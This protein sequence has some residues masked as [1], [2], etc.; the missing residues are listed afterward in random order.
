M[1]NF[2]INFANPWLLLLLIPA[3]LLTF[4]PYFR[5]NKRYRGTRNRIVSIVLHSIVM[6]LAISVLAGI[7]FEYDEPND[8][9]EV[10]LLVDASFSGSDVEDEKDEFIESVIKTNNGMFRLGIVSFGFDQVY[11][12]ELTDNMNNAYSQ[13]ISSALPD[14]TATDIEGALKYAASLFT[15]PE[16]GRIVLLTDGIETDGAAL[17]IIKNI[18]ADGIKVDTVDF[19]DDR[20]GDEVQ[21]IAMQG[22]DTKIKFTEEFTV[23]L[24]IQSSF[25]GDATITSYNDDE[26][27]GAVEVELIRGIQTVKIPFTFE[28]PNPNNLHK[29]SFEI[30]SRND[31]LTQNNTFNSYL[32]VESFNKVL[33]LEGIYGESD[34]VVRMLG[35]DFDITTVHIADTENVP[36]SLDNIRLYDQVILCNVSYSDMPVGFDKILYDYVYEIGGGLFTVCGNE[37]DSDPYDEEWEA[38]A[39]TPED[40]KASQYLKKLLPVDIINFTPPVAVIILIDKSGSMYNEAWNPV[41]EESKLYYALQGAEA[42]LDGLSERDYIGVFEL[43]DYDDEALGLTPA[44]Q[45]DKILNAIANI[46]KDGGGT[47]FS[48]AL[49]AAGEA[50]MAC[51]DVEKKHIIIITDGEPDPT[52]IELTQEALINNAANGITTS[53]VGI[54]CTTEASNLMKNLLKEYAGVSEDNFHNVADIQRVPDAIKADMD[55]PEIK[56]VNYIE[57]QPTINTITDITKGIEQEDMP[58]LDGFYGMK[59]KNADEISEASDLQVV[60]MGQYT[61]IYT[62]WK[63]GKGKVG[64]FGCDLNGT[65]SSDFID[66]AEGTQILQNIVASL[67]PDENIRLENIEVEYEGDNYKTQLNVYTE[68][69]EGEYVEITVTSPSAD[70]L[71][72]PTVQTIIA[73]ADENYTRLEFNVTTAGVHEI[74]AQKKDVTG[75]VKAEKRI[76]KALSYSEEYNIF[77][78]EDEAAALITDIAD[79]GHGYVLD[80]PWQVYENSSEYNHIT[81]DPIVPFIII[82]LTFLLLDIAVRKFKWKWIHEIVRD[83]KAKKNMEK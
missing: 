68:L 55:A 75:Q 14:T 15:N 29:L 23:E 8:E 41:F 39:F 73:G 57:F 65:W 26:A 31:T 38:N 74:L 13:Y 12:V 64:V 7:T 17:D 22:P 77:Y 5:M 20:H 18:A 16:Q 54:E 79:N 70:G 6:V 49:F 72:S 30:T 35:E 45:R 24:T 46:G 61:P 36:A 78:D 1:T 37:E 80:N 34:A 71:S 25:V 47:I 42:C 11:A 27:C 2:S 58:T 59:A 69:A 9:N 33:I 67:M 76:Y 50:L 66:T 32:L 56:D 43:D 10:I 52:N 44:T 4:I 3:F 62:Q 63:Y 21:I 48:S 60:L 28:K 82:V 83:V 19:T 53:I 40:I 51:T 81:I